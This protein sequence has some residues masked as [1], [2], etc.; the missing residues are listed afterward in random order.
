[1]RT[2]ILII[3]ALTF[4]SC[5]GVA[6]QPVKPEV[7]SDAVAKASAATAKLVIP[8]WIRESLK[9]DPSAR[10]GWQ[11]TATVIK[12]V[13]LPILDS[14]SKQQPRDQF[15]GI[16]AAIYSIADGI[17]IL[18]S[19][20]YSLI[21]L[22]TKDVPAGVVSGVIHFLNVFAGCIESTLGESK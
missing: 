1:M 8:P 9:A 14:G 21:D 19:G 4:V 2:S 16:P 15:W 10:E 17:V 3:L 11:Q 20:G 22:A 6:T 12:E 18:F 13:I 7:I 5:T